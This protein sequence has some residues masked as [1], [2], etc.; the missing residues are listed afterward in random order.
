MAWPDFLLAATWAREDLG[1]MHLRPD[2]QAHFASGADL[3]GHEAC[4]P[5]GSVWVWEPRETL[6]PG[7][8]TEM[9][10]VLFNPQGRREVLLL[11]R[12]AYLLP[13][14]W[15][16]AHTG[17]ARGLPHF[18]P[19]PPSCPPTLHGLGG[20]RGSLYTSHCTESPFI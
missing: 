2:S 20:R 16:G 13:W 15:E 12:T 9:D 14:P 5:R 11:V 8:T 10:P 3:G 17:Q 19:R 6:D 18:S 1:T 7:A 4:G